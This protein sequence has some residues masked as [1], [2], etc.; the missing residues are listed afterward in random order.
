M[1]LDNPLHIA[2]LVVIL[3]LIFG[4]K[5][6]PEIGRSLGSGMREFKD[7]ISGETNRQADS[8]RRPARPRTA[9]GAAGGARAAG[10]AGSRRA[11][12]P[13]LA[14]ATRPAGRRRAPQWMIGPVSTASKAD[15]G[16]CLSVFRLAS[17]QPGDGAPVTYQGEPLSATIRP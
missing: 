14:P 11:D 16:T 7:S 17:S 9:A 6:L 3:L 15:P 13:G 2:F 4:A 10:R 12:A 8:Q 5:R 1:G